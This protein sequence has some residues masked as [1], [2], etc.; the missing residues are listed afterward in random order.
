M[1]KTA[2]PGLLSLLDPRKNSVLE[3]INAAYFIS[4]F[5]IIL[6]YMDGMYYNLTFGAY[7]YFIAMGISIA[8]IVLS[9]IAYVHENKSLWRLSLVDYLLLGYLLICLISSVKSIHFPK[10]L[11]GWFS[12]NGVMTIAVF[13]CVFICI[14]HTFKYSDS[15]LD[16]MLV[17]VVVQ[18]VII[19]LQVLGHNPFGLYGESDFYATGLR[20]NLAECFAGTFGN[21]NPLSCWLCMMCVVFTVHALQER[22]HRIAFVF[23]A[24]LTFIAMCLIGVVLGPIGALV[25]ILFIYPF[26]RSYSF[27]KLV[28]YYICICLLFAL[29]LI[30]LFF[31]SSRVPR[32]SEVHRM[33]SGDIKI[34]DLHGRIKIWR[35]TLLSLKGNL[36]LG[37]GA[38][39]VGFETIGHFSRY[40]VQDNMWYIAS[41]WDAH[42]IYLNILHNSGILGLSVFLF[43]LLYGFLSCFFVQKNERRHNPFFA[44]AVS[45]CIAEF[46]CISLVAVDIYFVVFSAIAMSFCDE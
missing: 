22:K 21:T 41:A 37:L 35:D 33:L 24:L 30:V 5:S 25:A 20:T 39:S 19:L 32:L 15:L 46:L 2:R 10:T 23:G 34:T 26:A 8:Y 18:D 13:C 14:E 28:A 16:W 17:A 6:F 36:L 43:A 9:V 3:I 12:W 27:K 40:D 45:W 4:L 7:K 42:N 38:D 44:A 31:V 29:L 11:V 1:N